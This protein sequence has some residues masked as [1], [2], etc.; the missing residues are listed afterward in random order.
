M[1]SKL[2]SSGNIT[3]CY[4]LCLYFWHVTEALLGGTVRQKFQ[5][6]SLGFARVYNFT[7]LDLEVGEKMNSMAF[8]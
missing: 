6:N 2:I 4:L 5:R 7:E 3:Q 8:N 1:V